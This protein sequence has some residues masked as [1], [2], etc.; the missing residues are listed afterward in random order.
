[1]E[2]GESQHREGGEGRHA[3][4]I[5]GVIRRPRPPSSPAV[6]ARVPARRP[7]PAALVPPFSFGPPREAVGGAGWQ[8]AGSGRP[9]R[10]DASPRVPLGSPA[11]PSRSGCLYDFSR[12]QAPQRDELYG[13][14]ALRRVCR[15]SVM[16]ECF[17]APA[18][19]VCAQAE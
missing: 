1:M 5:P 3:R 4:I 17:E 14:M 6:L 19:R 7:R 10:A 18:V 13:A 11:R 16:A 15:H 12:L 2:G 8:I 9:V